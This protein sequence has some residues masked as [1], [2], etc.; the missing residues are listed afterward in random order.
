[1]E[2]IKLKTPKYWKYETS[3]V[4]RNII[5]K[6]LQDIELTHKELWELKAYLIQWVDAMPFRPKGFKT[7]IENADQKYLLEY[8]FELQKEWGIDPF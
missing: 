8:I 3:G 6:F 7:Y 2:Q 4:L 1:M 5:M